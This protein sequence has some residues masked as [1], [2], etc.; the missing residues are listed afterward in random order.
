MGGIQMDVKLPT[1]KIERKS[2]MHG[3][4]EELSI[5]LFCVGIIY[6]MHDYL[7]YSC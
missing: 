1:N 3:F 4:I 7:G 6:A 5:M 2:E